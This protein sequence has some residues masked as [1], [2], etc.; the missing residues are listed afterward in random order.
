MKKSVR[1]NDVFYTIVWSRDFSYDKYTAMRILPELAGIISIMEKDPRGDPLCLL[2]YGC[3]HDGLRMGF[4]NLMDP[5]FTKNELIQQRLE[6]RKLFYKYTVVDSNPIDMQDILYWL[7]MNNKPEFNTVDMFNDSKRYE[8]IY[9][10][11]MTLEDDQV[12]E[13]LPRIGL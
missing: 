10:K 7:I 1:N 4:K 2:V 13:R 12:M 8:N 9:V 11:E 6:G 3:W 5:L